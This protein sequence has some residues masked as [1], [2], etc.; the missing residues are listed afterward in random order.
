MNEITPAVAMRSRLQGDLREAMKQRD[1]RRTA[2][3][4]TLIAAIDN[5]E[6]VGVA[7]AKGASRLT[8]GSQYVVTGLTRESEVPRRLLGV[9]EIDAVLAAE[10]TSRIEAAGEMRRGGRTQEAL[11]LEADAASIAPY[12]AD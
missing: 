2:L 12:R 6:S 7:E 3:L 8:G 1:Q 5:A 11:V 9:D 10:Q 4:R